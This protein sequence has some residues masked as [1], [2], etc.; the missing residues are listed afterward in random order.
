MA[1]VDAVAPDLG[2]TQ[3]CRALGSRGRRCTGAGG[4]RCQPRGRLAPAHRGRCRTPNAKHSAHPE[5]FVRRP[6]VPQPL[7]VAV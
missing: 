2:A 5:R 1:A 7:P 3:A 6:P 4:R